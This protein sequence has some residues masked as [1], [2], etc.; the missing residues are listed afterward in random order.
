MNQTEVFDVVDPLRSALNVLIAAQ[1]R[2]AE[3]PKPGSYSQC[4]ASSSGLVLIYQKRLVENPGI[5]LL[6]RFSATQLDTSSVTESLIRMISSDGATL[7]T[8]HPL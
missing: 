8:N 7:S 2:T 4:F 3:N 6:A 1:T 5:A